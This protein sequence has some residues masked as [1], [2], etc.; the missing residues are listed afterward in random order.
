MIP[1]PLMHAA[2]A[3]VHAQQAHPAP[4]ITLP[5]VA[6]SGKAPP[7]MAKLRYISAASPT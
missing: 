6:V 3:A 5:G 7:W 4:Q 2:P 1:V